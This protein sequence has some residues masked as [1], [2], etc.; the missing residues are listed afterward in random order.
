MKSA[1][2]PA[3]PYQVMRL[4]QPSGVK[5]LGQCR[6]HREVNATTV[7]GWRACERQCGSELGWNGMVN[8]SE[9]LINVVIIQQAKDADRLGPKGMQHGRWATHTPVVASTL[10]ANKADLPHSGTEVKKSPPQAAGLRGENL[11]KHRTVASRHSSPRRYCGM[12]RRITSAVTLS[13][14]VRAPIALF[15]KAPRPTGDAC[16]AWELHAR[17]PGHANS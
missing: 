5:H 10:P 17:W 12:Y 2:P 14:T 15:Q 7:R 3:V 13:P 1:V 11:F 9:R 16:H 6:R 4:G 8:I